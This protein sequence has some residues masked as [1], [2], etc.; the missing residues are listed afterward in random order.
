MVRSRFAYRESVL[1]EFTPRARSVIVRA[2]E[3]A[4][5]LE[6]DCI[7]CE[8]ILLGLV[9]EQQGLAALLFVSA[10]ISVDRVREQV[11]SAVGAGAAVAPE[12]V[13]TRQ[14]KK[15]LELAVRE[16]RS[17][18]HY[19]VGSEHILLGLLRQDEGLAT[20]SLSLLEIDARRLAR[21]AEEMR[22]ANGRFAVN[23]TV[24]TMYARAH[25]ELRAAIQA[26]DFE[27]AALL[28]RRA[29]FMPVSV[30]AGTKADSENRVLARISALL[31]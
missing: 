5:A 18:S 1:R 19:F 27:R 3:E 14:A 4:R 25:V 13:F 11:V 2:D 9:H 26:R 17:I 31:R 29:R 8:H 21:V 7:G 24:L 22:R 28:H 10:D 20:R 30:N 23:P 6:H 12:V 15:V 16:A